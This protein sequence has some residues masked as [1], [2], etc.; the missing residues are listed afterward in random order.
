VL[1]H[2]KALCESA[3]IGPGTRVWAFAHIMDGA[4]IGS[5]C[6]VCDHAF[7]ETGAVVGDRVTIKNNVLLWEKVMIEDDVFL[8][9]NA[10]FTNDINPRAAH[11]KP[12]SEF[13]A[14]RVRNGATIGANATVV[15]G[16]EIGEHAFVGAGS[17]V[18]DDVPAHALVVGNPARQIGWA[19][20]CGERLAGDWK[21]GCGRTYELMEN[22][23]RLRDAVVG[24]PAG[25]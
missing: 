22:R 17:V 12:A 2:E 1:V 21:C 25:S 18:I 15:C 10:G 24:R 23:L 16:T 9:P 8:G 3:D 19:C 20:E 6:N 11:K 13:L 14:T 4:R 5:D 7:V